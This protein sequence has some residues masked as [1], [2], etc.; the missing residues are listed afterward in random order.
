MK[1]LFDLITAK[2]PWFLRLV[3]YLFWFLAFSVIWLIVKG[4]EAKTV[5]DK[6]LTDKMNLVWDA[7]AA[8]ILTERRVQFSVINDRLRNMERSATENTRALGRIEGKIEAIL[9]KNK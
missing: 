9:E 5:S 6:Y 4:W 2:A 3:F 1:P 8:P 7:R